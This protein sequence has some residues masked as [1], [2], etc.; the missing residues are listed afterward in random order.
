MKK[1]I[2]LLFIPIVSFSH[3]NN[4]I[5]YSDLDS[6]INLDNIVVTG[7][8]T[9]KIKTNSAVII[10]LINSNTINNVQACNLSESLSFQTGLRVE[11]NCQTCNYTQLRIN[12]MSGGFSQILINGR[13]TFSPLMGLYALEQ[14]PSNM[15]DKIEI[16]KGGGSTLYGSSAIGGTVNI[17]TRIPKKNSSQIEFF[18]TIIDNQSNDYSLSANSSIVS[19]SKLSGLSLFL[20][21]R[22][23]DYY[24]NNNDNY[25]EIPYLNNISFGANLFFIPSDNKKLNINF[26]KIYEYRYGGEMLKNTPAYIANQAEERRHNIFVGN[27]DY[28]LYFN[29]Y[30][31]SLISYYAYQNTDREH[32]TGIK[33]EPN[34]NEF[35]SF[36]L[37]PP[38]GNSNVET[39][40]SGFQ[41]N[42]TLGKK[43]SNNTL[44]LGI[45][46]LYDKVFDEIPSYNY[47]INQISKDIGMFL[48]S[49]WEINEKVILLT[50]IRTDFHNYID[51][52]IFSPRASILYKYDKRLQFRFGYGTGFR[53]PQALD[54][55]LHIAFSGGGLSRVI[56]SPELIEETSKSYNISVNYDKG[57]ENFIAGFTIDLFY[58]ILE[59]SFILQPIGEDEIGEIFEKQNGQGAKVKGINLETRINFDNIIQFEGGY[60]IQSSRHDNPVQYINGINGIKDFIRTPNKYGYAILNY[61]KSSFSTTLSYKYTGS[62]KIPHF[63][64]SINQVIDEV[65]DS[66]SFDNLSL[67]LSYTHQ[68]KTNSLD[69]YIGIKNIFNNYQ[70]DFDIGKNRDSNYIYGPV[71]PKSLYLGFKYSLN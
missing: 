27:I 4:E 40:N 28:E 46:L 63:A 17:I 51:K 31:S 16:M 25:S 60:T 7:T 19:E 50:G 62:M 70:N 61:S 71:L 49:D 55:D 11:N 24:D 47:L 68:I 26:N 65:I 10:N 5:R 36:L 57:Q 64:G 20:N 22:E 3:K 35:N 53:A 33:P 23:R 30:N 9:P 39:I 41:L 69:A 43:Y 13:P 1:L 8:K 42:H 6:I 14:F 2:L 48:Q 44:S 45:D 32:Y 18:N 15:I 58:N 54:T 12:G 67:K 21:K 38:Y 34:T 29:N 37:N 52:S 66:E 59:N 56:L